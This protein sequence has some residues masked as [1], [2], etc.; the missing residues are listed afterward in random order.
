MQRQPLYIETTINCELDDLWE[1]TQNPEKHQQWDLRFSTI[2]YLPKD[3]PDDPQR[4]LYS[5]KVLFACVKG[6]GEIVGVKS[7]ENGEATSALKFSSDDSISLIKSG[8]GY[9]KYIPGTKGIRFLT[10]YNYTTRWGFL[11]KLIDKVLFRPLMTRATAWSFDCLKNWLEK[12]IHPR[13]AF[14]AQLS[15][16]LTNLTLAIIWIYHGIF[17]KVLFPH[18]GEYQFLQKASI[19]PGHEITALF[20]FGIMEI[21]FGLLLLLWQTKYTHYCNILALIALAAGAFWFDPYSF[22]KPFDPFTLNLAM[23]MLSVIALCHFDKM[24]RYKNC[25]MR[26][27]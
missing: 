5:R 24:P 23:I 9:W 14:T 11:G 15:V 26:Q 19:F 13:E 18:S 22:V 4:F 10:G 16:F 12:G 25:I 1:H 20:C 17:P 6:I 7:K 8:S 3:K 21:C 27:P 2:E